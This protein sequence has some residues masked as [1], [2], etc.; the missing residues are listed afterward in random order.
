MEFT[1]EEI[2]VLK[3]DRMTREICSAPKEKFPNYLFN[4]V[5]SALAL[6]DEEYHSR[7]TNE[8]MKSVMKLK[9]RYN[10]FFQWL[11]AMQIYSDYKEYIESEYGSFKKIKKAVDKGILSIYLPPEPKLKKTRQNRTLLATGIIPSQKEFDFD[12][13]EW[14]ARTIEEQ[15]EKTPQYLVDQ[16]KDNDVFFTEPSKEEIKEATKALRMTKQQHRLGGLY[17]EDGNIGMN[18]INDF[19]VAGRERVGKDGKYHQPVSLSEA[20]KDMKKRELMFE[21]E[22]EQEGLDDY[23]YLNHRHVEREKAEMIELWNELAQEG[24]N[25]GKMIGNANL[26]TATMKMLRKEAGINV[27]MSKK[28]LKKW[29][30]DKA[31]HDKRIQRKRQ[32]DSQLLQTITQANKM[33]RII[34]ED[35]ILDITFDSFNNRD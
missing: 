6:D 12:F 21:S 25:V 34:N 4:P 22:L 2:K 23:V 26:N 33:H 18:I 16:I 29:K 1:Q 17:L 9:R 5:H 28:E 13:K 19:Y 32:N 27:P 35:D 14:A 20:V 31:E 15:A 7:V 10:N 11:D 24:W 3:L 8:N 30:K